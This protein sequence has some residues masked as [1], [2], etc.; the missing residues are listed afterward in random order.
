[1]W[2]AKTEVLTD[3]GWKA[4]E[5][6]QDG[7]KV[8]SLNLKNANVEFVEAQLKSKNHNGKYV[9]FDGMNCDGVFT[10]DH[11]SLIISHK[12]L[13]KKY[14]ISL[15]EGMSIPISWERKKEDAEIADDVLKLLV[16]IAA[17]GTIEN[18]DL[19][20]FHLKKDRKIKRLVALLKSLKINFSNNKQKDGTVKINFNT[21]DF[22]VG[23]RIKSFDDKLMDIS[24]RQ[25]DLVVQEYLQT[26]GNMTSKNSFQ[27]TT[28]RKEEAD[29]LQA[30][31]VLNGYSC[32]ILSRK[33]NGN[34]EYVI[35][36]GNKTSC[37]ISNLKVK[38][39]KGTEFWGIKNSNGTCF[40][41]RDGLVQITGV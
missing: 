5:D 19:I 38:S 12:G 22:L 8:A 25:A 14:A 7:V 17:D 28:A 40:V 15:Q 23:Y 29:V 32:N 21:P 36:S 33:K 34:Q 1:M 3:K 41:R 6:L 39:S 18:T 35:S 37:K 24:K 9:A 11:V 31:F 2:D 26:D 13:E 27:I 10:D 30:I 16:W 4:R 20:R